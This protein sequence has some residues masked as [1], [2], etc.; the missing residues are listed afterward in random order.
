MSQGYIEWYDA[1]ERN[2]NH[3]DYLRLLNSDGKDFLAVKKTYGRIVKLEETVLVIT[4]ENFD[5]EREITIIPKGW[6]INIK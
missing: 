4:E 2:L 5:G 6:I 3:E 1:V